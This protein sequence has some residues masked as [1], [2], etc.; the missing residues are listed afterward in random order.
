MPKRI[1][2]ICLQQIRGAFFF[3]AQAESSYNFLL[4]QLDA[5]HLTSAVTIKQES[6]YLKSLLTTSKKPSGLPVILAPRTLDSV[7][8]VLHDDMLVEIEP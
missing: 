5:N 1:C 6:N 2:V 8:D 4:R 7:E 3:K